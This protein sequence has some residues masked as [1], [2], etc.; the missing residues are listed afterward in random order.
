[1]VQDVRS[2]NTSAQQSD[3]RHLDTMSHPSPLPIRA[4]ILEWRK[5]SYIDSDHLIPEL[6]AVVK[7]VPVIITHRVQKLNPRRELL[8]RVKLPGHRPSPQHARPAD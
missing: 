7:L 5:Q 4:T 6:T 3:L 2:A 1:V 8:P